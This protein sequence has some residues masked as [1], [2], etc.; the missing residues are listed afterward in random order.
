MKPF[1]LETAFTDYFILSE[2]LERFSEKDTWTRYKNIPPASAYKEKNYLGV[3]IGPQTFL[4][5]YHHNIHFINEIQING[6]PY[7]IVSKQKVGNFILLHSSELVE[8]IFSKQHV[9][10]ENS[11]AKYMWIE[12]IENKFD[13]LMASKEEINN[14]NL[15]WKNFDKIDELASTR[16]DRRRDTP[17][18]KNGTPILKT[19]FNIFSNPEVVGI[20]KESEHA[21]PAQILT[22][23]EETINQLIDAVLSFAIKEE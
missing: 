9:N 23:N 15:I 7:S 19:D 14:R 13:V 8:N 16:T 2:A 1:T 21:Q 6:Q 11:N 22:F 5:P 18:Y 4:F 17:I 12:S 3:P 20:Y 10:Y